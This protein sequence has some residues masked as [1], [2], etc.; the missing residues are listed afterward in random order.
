MEK[1]KSSK[2]EKVVHPRLLYSRIRKVWGEEEFKHLVSRSKGEEEITRGNRKTSERGEDGGEESPGI[3]NVILARRRCNG[4]R[5]PGSRSVS[6]I[7]RDQVQRLNKPW[8]P[9]SPFRSASLDFRP[10]IMKIMI[11][12]SCQ[13]WENSWNTR[14]QLFFNCL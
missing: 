3:R 9:V 13:H 10:F 1:E 11:N 8:L 5:L 2:R 14:K 4:S 6:G 7:E 12:S